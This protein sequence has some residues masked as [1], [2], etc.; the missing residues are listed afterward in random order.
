MKEA[1]K[2]LVYIREYRR[3][4]LLNILFN[5]LSIFFSVFSLAMIFPFLGLLFGT[6]AIVTEVPEFELKGSVVIQYFYYYLSN[7]IAPDGLITIEGQTRGLL[8]ICVLVSVLFLLKNLFRYFAVFFMATIRYGMVKDIR[9]DVYSKILMLPFAYFTERRKG[10]ILA[11]MTTDILEIEVSIIHSIEVI[12]KDPVTI[13]VFLIALFAISPSLTV[14]VIVL[15]PITGYLIGKVG[16]SLKKTSVKGQEK[17]GILISV[18]EETLSGLRIIK[19]FTAEKYSF[20]KFLKVNTETSKIF[21]R[22]Q[23]KRDLSSPMSEF[24]GVMVMVIILWFG[25]KVVISGESLSPEMFITYIVMFSQIISPSKSFTTAYFN[26]Q[27]GLASLDRINVILGESSTISE[28]ENADSIASFEKS[29]E[30]KDMSF[31]YDKIPTLRNINLEISKGQTIALVGQSGSGK[32]TIAN[33]LPRFYDYNQGSILLDGKPITDYKINDLR[34]L[35][36][37]V[38]QESILFNDSVRNNIAFGMPEASLEEIIAAA[39]IA[40]ANGFIEDLEQG[41]ETNIGDSGDRLSGGQKQRLSIAR[42]ILKN[43]P[44]LILDEATSSLD[45]ESERMVQ[46]AIF[47]LMENRTSLVIAH[48]LSTIQHADEICVVQD[49][50]IIER[51]KHKDLI[52]NNGVYKKLHDMQAFT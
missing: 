46:D 42:A 18:I 31:S 39:K 38:T 21:V 49:G 25:G 45:T 24:L 37:I 16:K 52:I 28:K 13:L 6:Q 43:P 50:E 3:S 44:I 47:K 30:F 23:R 10:D 22:M 15:L 36:G 7:I 48:R 33:L 1:F 17:I 34:K 14:F 19:A 51:G 9:N 4:L 8:F 12:F 27:K 11:R 32:T 29:I 2:I 40:N 35:M 41:Y 26:I 20:Q 5:G